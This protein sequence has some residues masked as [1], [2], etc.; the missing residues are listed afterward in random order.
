MT[1]D[2]DN[3]LGH[4]WR[5]N[6]DKE[7]TN[8][9]TP[10]LEQMVPGQ[11]RLDTQGEFRATGMAL[12]GFLYRVQWED[13]L[14]CFSPSTRAQWAQNGLFHSVKISVHSKITVTISFVTS[15]KLWVPNSKSGPL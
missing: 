12:G 13:L 8:N 15:L 7:Q 4:S 9:R 2:V 5:L 14:R 3:P 6:L 10:A 1:Y 11:P